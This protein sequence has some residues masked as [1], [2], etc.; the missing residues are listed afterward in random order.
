MSTRLSFVHLPV[1]SN[2]RHG[3][4]SRVRRATRDADGLAVFLD[5]H[6]L[7]VLDEVHDRRRE[8]AGQQ[9]QDEQHDR[10]FDQRQPACVR[11]LVFIVPVSH[12]PVAS[13]VGSSR[14]PA[15][16]PVDLSSVRD[17][18]A[19]SLEQRPCRRRRDRDAT[20]C[21]RVSWGFQAISR[22]WRASCTRLHAPHIGG[23]CLDRPYKSRG[24]AARAMP[25][26]RRR[27]GTKKRAARAGDASRPRL[28]RRR[29]TDL[30]RRAADLRAQR[31][32][33][34]SGPRRVS[35]ALSDAGERE[36]LTRSAGSARDQVAALFVD[37][38]QVVVRRRVPVVEADRAHQGLAGLFQPA[39]RPA[40]RSRG[41]SAPRRSSGPA[42]RS[43]R[44]SDTAAS[45]LPDFSSATPRLLCALS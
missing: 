25:G 6:P 16:W 8:H 26:G 41:W 3:P 34:R 29:R 15:A 38:R 27:R 30:R 42:P 24:G 33:P 37:E 23:E 2:L 32:H 4:T 19:L 44:N 35:A 7:R 5:L 39:R 14:Q 36:E 45:V 21:P 17:A 20:E 11:K 43:M 13:A 40:A 28:R 22:E 1:P 18:F 9:H 10:D 12:H 31:L